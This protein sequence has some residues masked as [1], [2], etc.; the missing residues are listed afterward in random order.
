MKMF[1]IAA[2]VV[3]TGSLTGLAHATT[4]TAKNVQRQVVS[5]ADLNLENAADAAIL[6]KRIVSAARK[7]CGVYSSPMPLEITSPLRA[8]AADATARAV[9]EVNAPMLTANIVVRNIAE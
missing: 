2:A 9:A 6:H 8:C 7:V 5:Y 1:A 4:T 3:M